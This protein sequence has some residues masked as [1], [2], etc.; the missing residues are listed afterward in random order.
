MVAPG[1]TRSQ[2]IGHTISHYRIVEKLGGGGMGVVYKAEDTK[3][4]RFV[5]LKFLPEDLARDPQALSRFQREA[6]A[7]S[8][9]NHPNICT[10]YE[11]DE[12][13]G[14]A[15]I[16]M[17]FLDGMTLKHRIAG[18]PME[19][20]ALL[21]LAIE[22][23]DA[24]DAAHNEGIVHR[25]IKP[26][27]V[28]V[29]KRGH[30]K[31]LDFGLAKVTATG[32]KPVSDATETGTGEPHLTSPGTAVGTVAYMSP[33]QVRAR[34]LDGRT[35][36]FSFGVVL[37]EMATGKLPF[38]G[39]SSA[40]VFT[41]I[42]EH[43]PPSPS[44]LNPQL[45]PRLEEIINKTLEKDR[46]LRCQTAAELR[47]DLK[48]LKRDTVSG[49]T[50]AHATA[51]AT[52]PQP[53]A[54]ASSNGRLITL[55]AGLVLASAV[56]A[57]F[58]GRRT[59]RVQSGPPPAYHQLTFRHGSIRVARF[60][61]DGRTVLYSA[62]WE[63]S[64]V[65]VFS[66]RP[67]SPESR[68][69]GLKNA[70]VLAVS[71][72]GEMAVLLGS[73][74]VEP[75]INSGVLAR[76]PLGG[77]AP[78]EVLEGVQ[79]ADWSPDGSNFA[80]VRDMGGQNRLEYPIGTVLYQTAGWISHMRISP[81]GDSIAFIDHPARRDD[82][83]AIAIVDLKGHKRTLSAGWGS[84]QGL[85]WA[86]GGA[87]IWFTST[88]IGN[89]R[90]LTAVDTNGKERLFA[91]EPGA[92]T[93]QDVG[94]DGSLLL[95]L[96][97]LR[98]GM[99]ARTQ[100]DA[101]ERDLSWLDW[102]VPADLSADGKTVVFTEAGEGGGLDYAAYTRSIDGSP[103]VRLGDGSAYA[104]S[105]DG[106]WVISSVMGTVSQFSLLPTGVGAARPLTNDTLDHVR[107]EWFPDGKRFVF[108]GNE[109]G[110]GV[111]L[112]V[113]ALEGGK[114]QAISPE[115]VSASQWEI[116]PDGKWVA[117]VGPDQNGYLYPVD[118]GDPRPIRGFP[119]GDTPVGWTA[120]GRTLFVYRAGDLPAR[121]FR[122]DPATGQ[123]QP[124]KDLMPTDAAGITDLGPI[125]I[126][127]DAKTYVYEYGRTLS[128]LYL[129]EGVK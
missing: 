9:L 28:F 78:R 46:D 59:A 121:V 23:A 70:E 100:S 10:V 77:G 52:A 4:G 63:E 71:S 40:V 99:M 118:G 2:V 6:K 27:N 89:G 35:D 66:T 72:T 90:S 125:L 84:V 88:K 80:I 69:F 26:A 68:P 96:D 107:A 45:P 3:L 29:T 64:P 37:Y 120:D 82:A 108:M 58:L 92:L 119:L 50:A 62:A 81:Q 122:L 113:Q 74:A 49:K 85:A 73:R 53:V 43:D 110:H 16:A 1:Q 33:E 102:S 8:A 115:G 18:R 41:Q 42:L 79:W 48:R 57:F 25:D 44:S 106:K 105:P 124:W 24:L 104:I 83:G 20:E 117:A 95:T 98:A 17:E 15:F 22:I 127:P 116:S 19:T 5:A 87:E 128:D 38:S 129:V 11:I 91:R 30:A 76:V 93:L 86:P 7:A 36:L 14:Q 112:Y 67:G 60:A 13:N 94:R 101:K 47:G 97:A 12:Q 65:E 39:T 32:A 103:A 56:A 55:V 61:P 109:P 21:G 111:R 123:K 54:T 31:I 75:Y 34:E 114:P 51:S 126:T